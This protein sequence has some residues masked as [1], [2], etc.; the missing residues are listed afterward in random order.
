MQIHDDELVTDH[1]DANRAPASD[2]ITVQELL[3]SRDAISLEN[4]RLSSDLRRS[5]AFLAV[6]QSLSHT[7]NFGWSIAN[8]EI[9]WSAE[10]YNIFEYDR[11]IKPTLEV[12]LRRTHPDDRQV[13]RQALTQASAARTDFDEVM[14]SCERPS[15]LCDFEHRLLMRDGAV[16]HLRVS[17]RALITTSENL[18]FVGA[19][20]DVTAAKQAEEKI[21]QDRQELQCIV[22]AIPSIVAVHNPDGERIYVNRVALEYTGLSIEEMLAESAR[23][24]VIHPEDL[25][26]LREIRQNAF[27]KGLPFELERRLRGKDGKY[28]WFLMRYNPVLDELGRITGQRA[29]VT[30]AKKSIANFK[31][32]QNMPIGAAVTLRADRMYEFLDR[33]VS[34][35]LPRV[36]DFRGVS[37]RSFDGRGNYTM[38]LRDQLIFPEISY[39]K[40]DKQKGMN[41]TIVTTAPNDNQARTLL[42]HM[43][44]PFRA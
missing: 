2:R 8:G 29:V 6:A 40:V 39:E 15:R 30:R 14:E 19:V 24:R 10:T 43:G 25:E 4:V 35:V 18:E 38:G 7:G 11:A 41:V 34:I 26:P 17:A 1:A 5:E 27:K 23:A 33:L 42:K 28:R 3:A 31:L 9:Y 16:K 22:D 44:M 36:R 21:R 37:T 32:R 12:V 13:V 20:T